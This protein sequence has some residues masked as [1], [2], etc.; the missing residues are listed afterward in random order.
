MADMF[1]HHTE[2][3]NVVGDISTEGGAWQE[4]AAECVA[5]REEL[6]YSYGKVSTALTTIVYTLAAALHTKEMHMLDGRMIT[7]YKSAPYR[8]NVRQEHC[9]DKVH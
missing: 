2:E 6:F 4:K 7:R 9:I 3:P 8:L 1:N 5:V